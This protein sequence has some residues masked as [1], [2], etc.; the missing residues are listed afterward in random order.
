[1][2]SAERTAALCGLARQV[3]VELR[4]LDPL[5]PWTFQEPTASTWS[6]YL[7][8]AGAK[9]IYLQLVGNYDNPD[10]VEISGC[11]NVGKNHQY[12]TVYENGSRVSVTAITV[13]LSRGAQAI[14]KEITR[15]FLPEY[16]RIFSLAQD[17]V[18]DE[19]EYQAQVSENLQNLA[20]AVGQSITIDDANNFSLRNV[21]N[22]YGKVRVS[23]D[24]AQLD[25]HNLTLAQAK[26]ILKYIHKTKE[27][28]EDQSSS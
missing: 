9:R 2:T 21:G 5:H 12:V 26:H 14:A 25:L 6:V 28:N 1:M 4:K 18:R 23:N 24:D 7:R 27:T 11:L 17:K 16:S 22:I 8:D 20:S 15:R 3:A 19:Q 10:R 13:G